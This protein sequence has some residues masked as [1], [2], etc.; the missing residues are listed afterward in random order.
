MMDPW[1]KSLMMPTQFR[2]MSWTT[3]SFKVYFPGTIHKCSNIYSKHE[4]CPEKKKKKKKKKSTEN[5]DE[6]IYM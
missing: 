2:Q 4:P 6:Y 3:F 5:R 1:V